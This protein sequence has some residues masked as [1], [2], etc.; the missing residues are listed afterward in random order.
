MDKLKPFAIPLIALALL[1]VWYFFVNP[2]LAEQPAPEADT[3]PKA[4]PKSDPR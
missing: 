2:R 4:Q 3:Q 1:L